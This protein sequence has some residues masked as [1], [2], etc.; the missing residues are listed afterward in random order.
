MSNEVFMATLSNFLSLARL[1]AVLVTDEQ[2]PSEVVSGFGFDN[3]L[4]RQH[5]TDLRNERKQERMKDAARVLVD[6]EEQ[7]QREIKENIDEAR[8]LRTIAKQK[9]EHATE[10][11]ARLMYANETNNWIPL[12]V[13]KFPTSIGQ[14]Y[15]TLDL[16]KVDFDKI[17][18]EGVSKL[19]AYREKIK[20]KYKNSKSTS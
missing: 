2:Q 11:S 7:I 5:V 15:K 12:L 16:P 14:V 20:Q 4:L 9:V 18:A 17:L 8:R 3:Q 19:N 6:V 10:L 13:Y 1:T